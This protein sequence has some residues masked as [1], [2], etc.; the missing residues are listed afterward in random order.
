MKTLIHLNINRNSYEIAVEPS[1]IL[2][3]VLRDKL[4]LIGTKKGC[5][6]GNC[7]ACTVL[8]DGKPVSS[9]LLLAIDARDKEITTIE[10]LARNGKL[11]PLQESFVKHGAFQ[12]GYCTPGAI[13]AAKALLDV[14]RHPTEADVREAL[15]GNL[16]RCTGYTRI[17]QAVLA[18]SELS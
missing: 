5:G 9:C 16:C 13:L 15:V 7:G 1:W 17:V 12:C 6:T 10:G 2:T 14:N 3:D 11:H 4:G 18:A 8:L